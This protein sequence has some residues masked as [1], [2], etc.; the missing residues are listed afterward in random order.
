MNRAKFAWKFLLKNRCA[1]K[2]KSRTSTMSYTKPNFSFDTIKITVPGYIHAVS[3]TFA[4]YIPY[5]NSRKSP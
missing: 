1:N 3:A 4:I 5:T 2:W